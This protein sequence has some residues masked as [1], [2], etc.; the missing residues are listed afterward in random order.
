MSS[1]IFLLSA[2]LLDALTPHQVSLLLVGLHTEDFYYTPPL[3]RSVRLVLSRHI[4]LVHSC[5]L[6]R[7][8][9]GRF[10][11][12]PVPL[13]SVD[14]LKRLAYNHFTSLS[15]SSSSSSVGFWLIG[16]VVRVRGCVYK[17][18]SAEAAAGK[19]SV[20]PLLRAAVQFFGL[21]LGTGGQR[22]GFLIHSA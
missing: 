3:S 16:L 9:S 12:C 1:G 10:G 21:F 17:G 8:V 2:R 14:A 6:S 22:S 4:C 5:S 19:S 7:S 13:S 18:I 15:S 11:V 20:P